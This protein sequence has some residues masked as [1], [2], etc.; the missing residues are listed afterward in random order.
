MVEDLPGVLMLDLSTEEVT[1]EMNMVLTNATAPLLELNNAI[2]HALSD[3]I[4]GDIDSSRVL[5]TMCFNEEWLYQEEADGILTMTSTFQDYFNDLQVWIQS[6]TFYSMIVIDCLHN[7]VKR[8]FNAFSHS[9]NS[10]DD[11]M[12]LGCRIKADYDVSVLVLLPYS[13]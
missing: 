13:A 11:C 1:V 12:T 8:Y 2:A 7:S 5:E 4:I 10:F 6:R 9:S 3:M